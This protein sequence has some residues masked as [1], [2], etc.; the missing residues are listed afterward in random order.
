L[1]VGAVNNLA[2]A[3]ALTADQQS[4]IGFYCGAQRASL[5]YRVTNC[6]SPDYGAVRINILP[7]G[8]E[9]DDRNPPRTNS[10]QIFSLSVGN[11]N[12][13]HAERLRTIVRFTVL[14]LS[15]QAALYNFLSPFGGTHW[16]QPRS[17]QA[18]LGL[19]F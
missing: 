8:A 3:L 7:P 15:N 12:L 11:D 1:V 19:A 13:F 14:N 16:V 18:Q 2:D 17:Y 5:N 10:R 9:N 4:M 6:N